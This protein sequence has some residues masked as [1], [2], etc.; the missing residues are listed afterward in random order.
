MRIALV[1]PVEE[2]IPPRTYGGIETIV[3]LLDGAL[4]DRGHEVVL[5]ASG[6]SRSHGR[7]LPLTD[8]PI[9]V[10][11]RDLDPERVVHKKEAAAQ[12]AAQL[13]PGL[14][15]DVVLNHSWRLID[16]LDSP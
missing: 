8:A 1:A 7:L 11:G 14:G 16:H 4:T 6:G 3:H 2:S 13:L 15:V 10:G 5:L 12:F 9:A